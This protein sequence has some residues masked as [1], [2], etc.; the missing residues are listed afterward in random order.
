M[1]TKFRGKV[2]TTEKFRTLLEE[3]LDGDMGWFFNQYVYGTDIPEYKFS[4]DWQE[5]SSSGKFKVTC[6]IVQEKVPDDFQMMVPLTVFFK[7]DKYVHLKVWVDQPEMDVDLPLL[8]YKPEKI[9]FN[10]YDAVLCKVKYQ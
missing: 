5:D 6:H 4:S 10:T 9:I 2:I 8:P 1:V 3:H 7:D